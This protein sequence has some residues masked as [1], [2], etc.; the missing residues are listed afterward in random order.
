M[1]TKE[2]QHLNG[3]VMTM[4]TKELTSLANAL[5]VSSLQ[6][7]QHPVQD[8]INAAIVTSFEAYKGETGCAAR[9]AA[10]F[11]EHPEE[12]ASRMRWALSLVAA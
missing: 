3:D 8:E 7:S 9:M 5:F 12:A 4:A 6:P 2:P 10:E 11:G 1:H